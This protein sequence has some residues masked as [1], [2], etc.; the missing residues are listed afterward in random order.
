MICVSLFADEIGSVKKL[1]GECSLIELR[2]DNGGISPPDM[3]IL[4]N[5]QA[6]I[7][8]TCRAGVLDISE[9]LNIL[10]MAID[11]GTE[12]IDIDM[13]DEKDFQKELL[14][15]LKGS[16]TKLIISYH[17]FERTPSI[18]E[19]QS[20]ISKC[21]EY[22]PDIIKIACMANSA[23][24]AAKILALYQGAY[25]D[26]KLIALSMGE[27]GKI[28]RIAAPFLGAP[29][30]YASLGENKATASGQINYDIMNQIFEAMNGK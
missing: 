2:L 14:N 8:S 12:Y 27:C 26:S 10:K 21:A 15:Y 1:A 17:D 3:K 25:V 23:G 30:T 22:K 13:D 11:S 16:A 9:R 24:D 7:I 20:I 19:L 29:F 4:Y 28:S 5:E 6:T 18:D